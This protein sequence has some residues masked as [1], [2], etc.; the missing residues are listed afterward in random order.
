MAKINFI[1]QGKGGVGKSLVSFFLAQYFKN[2]GQETLCFDT[3]PVNQTFASFPA[4]NVQSFDLLENGRIIERTFDQFVM[5]LIEAPED[6][7][8]VIDN[9]ASTFL[10]LCAY[11]KE[12][13]TISLLQEQGHEVL[14]HSVI[15]GGPSILDTMNGLQ[16]LLINFPDVP[17]AVWLNEYFGRT[18]IDGVAVEDS[19]LVKKF[20]DRIHAF[21]HIGQRNNDLF[22]HDFDDM[23]KRRL[24][25]EEARNEPSIWILNRQR[26]VMIQ[27]E[28]FEQISQANL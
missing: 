14:L 25:F 28:T 18:E 17:I 26:L 3:D 8:I 24:T 22:A 27:R 10:P 12:N 9:G 11:L 23:L 15:T 13:D 1:L 20:S 19:K 2:Q 7:A 6:A 21:I 5:A 16:A 4:L